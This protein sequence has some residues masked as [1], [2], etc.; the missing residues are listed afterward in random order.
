MTQQEFNEYKRLDDILRESAERIISRYYDI[1]VEM[2]P[3]SKRDWRY[4]V[5][6][7][8]RIKDDELFYYD[9]DETNETLPLSLLT[10]DDVDAALRDHFRKSIEESKARAKAE[11]LCRQIELQAASVARQ[12]ALAK[13]LTGYTSFVLPK[14]TGGS[15]ED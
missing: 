1:H 8:E 12:T 10:A 14:F 9:S 13:E 4:E 6:S 7:F 3:K 15:N 11:L 2:Y 5:K